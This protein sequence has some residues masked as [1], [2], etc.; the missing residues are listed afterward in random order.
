M[1]IYNSFEEIDFEV[2]KLNLER[3]IAW[4]EI[5]QSGNE[6]QES[7]SPYN[8][9]TPIISS[10]KKFGILFLLKKIFRK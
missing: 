2:K 10:I 7:L 6:M 5:K 1:R 8:W 4:E 9:I 3:K